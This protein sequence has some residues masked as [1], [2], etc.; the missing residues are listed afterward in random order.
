MY[1]QL[2]LALD[3]RLSFKKGG[4]LVILSGRRDDVPEV[5][6]QCTSSDGCRVVPVVIR[7]AKPGVLKRYPEPRGLRTLHIRKDMR[8]L[9]PYDWG[10]PV[11]MATSLG[12]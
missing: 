4:T 12:Q 1:I 3:H 6:L 9:A 7:G 5:Y 2:Q 10:D 8:S 11:V